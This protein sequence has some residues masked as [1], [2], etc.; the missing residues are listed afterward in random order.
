[1]VQLRTD[2]LDGSNVVITWESLTVGIPHLILTCFKTNL[3]ADELSRSGRD[4][5]ERIEPCSNSGVHIP[6]A[7]IPSKY[8]F[9]SIR[10]LSDIRHFHSARDDGS[11]LETRPNIRFLCLG[12]K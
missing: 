3:V 12:E 8:R 7:L 2:L 5:Y 4:S 9:F 6:G 10:G 1:M 11:T